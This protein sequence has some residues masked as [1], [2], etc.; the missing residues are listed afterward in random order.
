MISR[1]ITQR[2]FVGGVEVAGWRGGGG[3]NIFT[4]SLKPHKSMIFS[5]LGEETQIFFQVI[6]TFFL[7]YSVFND[8]L[9]TYMMS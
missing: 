8:I 3:R 7:N 9:V 1:S 6:L 2:G 4:L 5:Y